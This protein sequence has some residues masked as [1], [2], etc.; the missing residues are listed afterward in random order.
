MAAY[1]TRGLPVWAWQRKRPDETVEE[2]QRR[3]EREAD[4]VDAMYRDP[5]RGGNGRVRPVLDDE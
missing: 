3:V 5:R 1:G 4:L 2:F